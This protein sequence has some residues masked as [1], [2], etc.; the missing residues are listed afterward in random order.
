MN[1]TNR[2]KMTFVGYLRSMGPGVVVVLTWLGAGDLVES[3]TAGGNYGYMLMW[4]FV[5][6]LFV[7]YLFVS[8]ISRYQLFNP[9]GE[10]VIA[11]LYRVH[12]L[13]APFIFI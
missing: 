10:S 4:S 13:Y 9:R 3:A 2:Q 8:I 1:N 5:L 11:G 7:R 6:A 12:R